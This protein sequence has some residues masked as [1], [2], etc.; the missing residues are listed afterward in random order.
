MGQDG[1]FRDPVDARPVTLKLSPPSMG[2]KP[3]VPGHRGPFVPFCFYYRRDHYRLQDPGR[4]TGIVEVRRGG[5]G[6][7]CR[8][9][10]QP[11]RSEPKA[12][13]EY[14]KG[15]WARAPKVETW[16]SLGVGKVFVWVKQ[17]DG[18][19]ILYEVATR[20]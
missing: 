3:V 9:L 12:K 6:V 2:V 14:E 19:A 13:A 18:G 16:E 5:G 20:S 1:Q 7:Q 11:F 8:F 17:P 10:C 4:Q 15:D